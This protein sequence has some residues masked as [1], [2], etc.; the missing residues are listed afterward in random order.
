[1]DIMDIATQQIY[2]APLI[3]VVA[4]TFTTYYLFYLHR[5]RFLV[6]K[7]RKD[8]HYLSQCS[9]LEAPS[10]STSS[11]TPQFLLFLQVAYYTASCIDFVGV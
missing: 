4:G 6:V 2:N 3:S 10:H 7:A 8:I 11:I 9:S 5:S 1:M